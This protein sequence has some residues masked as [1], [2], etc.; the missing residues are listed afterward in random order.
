LG[1]ELD[2]G[3]WAILAGIGFFTVAGLGGLFW[4]IIQMANWIFYDPL[5][6][7]ILMLVIIG[8]F[9][10][11]LGLVHYVLVFRKQDKEDK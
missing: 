1:E 2:F 9:C 6:R 11:V 7:G 3:D 5:L 4:L 8:I 10:V